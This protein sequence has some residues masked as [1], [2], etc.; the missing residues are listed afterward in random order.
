MQIFTSDFNGTYRSQFSMNESSYL[1]RNA[2]EIYE[3]LS[4]LRTSVSLV[5]KVKGLTFKDSFGKS[6]ICEENVPYVRVE[7]HLRIIVRM[8]P[9]L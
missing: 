6:K 3:S 8:D 2:S 9:S 7:Y 5:Q 4:D 1:Y